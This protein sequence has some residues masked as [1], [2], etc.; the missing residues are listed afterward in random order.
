MIWRRPENLDIPDARLTLPSLAIES[1]T[2]RLLTDEFERLHAWNR[3][4]L[5]A[6][7][8][9]VPDS[10]Q[11]IE[12][13]TAFPEY[14]DA[15]PQVAMLKRDAMLREL[16]VLGENVEPGDPDLLFSHTY[17][18][19]VHDQIIYAYR[20]DG[21]RIPV[22]IRYGNPEDNDGFLFIHLL[23]ED[24]AKA[25]IKKVQERQEERELDNR[26]IAELG[27]DER[28]VDRSLL[29]RQ[30]LSL[31]EKRDFIASIDRWREANHPDAS[32]LDEQRRE[33]VRRMLPTLQLAGDKRSSRKKVTAQDAKYDRAMKKLMHDYG[34]ELDPIG[35]TA[36]K[37][38]ERQRRFRALDKRMRLRCAVLRLGLAVE[39]AVLVPGGM[40]IGERLATKIGDAT[41][42]HEVTG[43][44][45]GGTIG[46]GLAMF[47][48][49]KRE[50]RM[51]SVQKFVNKFSSSKENCVRRQLRAERN[52]ADNNLDWTHRGKWL[53]YIA[54]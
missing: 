38:Q 8:P 54:K 45:I 13:F 18:D 30:T 49:L 5:D 46:T 34:L 31:K 17:G 35:E 25:H 24:S 1:P 2:Q 22:L 33:L 39:A 32:L 16:G 47:E 12:L 6:F 21:G 51:R 7:D 27:T 11:D 28:G 3:S 40:A 23:S 36:F 41:I 29:A 44:M 14:E 37:D 10:R 42:G 19:G 53:Q 48:I 43:I 9:S 52:L 15:E 4:V 20:H 26:L 50:I